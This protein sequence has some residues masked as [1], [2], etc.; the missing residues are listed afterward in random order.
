MVCLSPSV[1]SAFSGPPQIIEEEMLYVSSKFVCFPSSVSHLPDSQLLSE[2]VLFVQLM[3]PVS[4]P[5]IS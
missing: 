5:V 3:L 2:A 4:E 1:S